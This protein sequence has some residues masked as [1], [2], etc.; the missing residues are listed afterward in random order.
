[1][2]DPIIPFTVLVSGNSNSVVGDTVRATVYS[3]GTAR[4]T[5]TSTLNSNKEALLE[6]GNAEAVVSRGD[7]VVVSVTGSSLGG[8]SVTTIDGS[9]AEVSVTTAANAFPSR[10]L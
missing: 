5:A 3:G 1:M 6:L 10:S 7:T 4:G 2:P 9:Q 8:G